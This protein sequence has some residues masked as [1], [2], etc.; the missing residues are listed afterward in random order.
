MNPNPK[1]LP[2]RP[3]DTELVF[4]D[5]PVNN[6]RESRLELLLEHPRRWAVIRDTFA[7]LKGAEWAAKALEFREVEYPPGR[8]EF[9]TATVNGLHRLYARYLG[10]D[11]RSEPM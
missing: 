2:R 7:N 5:P 6:W 9:A 11:T 10:P 8:W 1:Y 4:E 3:T